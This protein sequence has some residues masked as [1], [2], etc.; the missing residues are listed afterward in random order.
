MIG[1]SVGQ[2]SGLIAVAVFLGKC[3]SDRTR[4]VKQ[5]T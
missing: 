1:L 5:H 2:V 3:L 4:S